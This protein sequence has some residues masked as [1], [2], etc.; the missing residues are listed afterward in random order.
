MI[1]KNFL[2]FIKSYIKIIVP[3]SLAGLITITL[4]NIEKIS[5][6][7]GTNIINLGGTVQVPS[8]EEKI[9]P[10]EDNK[11]VLSNNNR[12]KDKNFSEHNHNVETIPTA[13]TSSI[14]VT[15]TITHKI[16]DSAS[17]AFLIEN[18]S[19]YSDNLIKRDEKRFY[20]LKLNSNSV[21]SLLFSASGMSSYQINIQDENIMNMKFEVYEER[22]FSKEMNIY[23]KAGTYTIRIT[24]GKSWK[25]K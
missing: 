1:M 19:E 24:G 23:L 14:A 25:K 15:D 11:N 16:N 13:N 5:L 18:N 12:G 9:K 7:E 3:L 8:S 21:V 6:F 17:T 20:K 4:L 10:N 22:N 2:F